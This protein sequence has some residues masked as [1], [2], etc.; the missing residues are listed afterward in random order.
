MTK[1]F[2]VWDRVNEKFI[3]KTIP[4]MVMKKKDNDD[5]VFHE[6]IYDI[7]QQTGLKDINNITIYEGDIVKYTTF[8]GVGQV[9]YKAPQFKAHDPRLEPRPLLSLE[10]F[11][12]EIVSHIHIQSVLEY[13]KNI[14]GE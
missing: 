4:M 13:V 10:G 11:K 12:V 9:V 8:D 2:R 14:E 3:Y 6:N 5:Y 1:Y 7:E